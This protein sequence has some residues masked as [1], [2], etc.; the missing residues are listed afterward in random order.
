MLSRQNQFSVQ[1]SARL[2]NGFFSEKNVLKVVIMNML[3]TLVPPY[4][5][6]I[7]LY[8]LLKPTTWKKTASAGRNDS[9]LNLGSKK[10]A[11]LRILS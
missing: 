10:V 6:T 2:S 11:M 7:Y 1:R 3:I 5:L 9:D 8:L 4:M